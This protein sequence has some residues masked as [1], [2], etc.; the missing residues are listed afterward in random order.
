MDCLEVMNIVI[1]GSTGSVGRQTLDIV[2]AHAN[3]FRV[4]G[5]SA[6]NN[7]RLLSEQINEFKPL[8]VS[9][10]GSPSLRPPGNYNLVNMEEIA[11]L[12]NIDIL[13]AASSGTSGLGTILSAIKAGKTVA[14]ANKEALV[15]AGCIIMPL[16]KQHGAQ[17]RP[18]DSE[19]SAIWQCIVGEKS[20]PAKIILTASGGPF[21]ARS[22]EELEKVT[23]E[24]TLRHPS[25]QMGHKITVDSATLMNKGLEVIEAHWLFDMPFAKIDVLIHPQSIIHSMVEFSDGSVKAQLGAPD[26]R[27]PIQYAFSHPFRWDNTSIPHLDYKKMKSLE[28]EQPDTVRFPCL[29]LAIEAGAKG[30]T[31]PAA[32][33]ATD[34]VAVEMFLSGQITF[35][36]IPKVIETVLEK[37]RSIP[38]PTIED[39]I[40]VAT[41]SRIIAKQVISQETFTKWHF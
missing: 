22:M 33:C 12:D 40:N 7:L 25:W 31:L 11:S 32:L 20:T 3:R 35:N 10:N 17:I 1:L 15:A 34:E 8:Y 14:L 4:I 18:V 39:I 41:E 16:Q 19:H 29:K 9:F 30:G 27:L 2:R 28:F 5:L 26:M 21:R 6:G 38:Q 13:V 37:H 23:P 24:Q 36:S